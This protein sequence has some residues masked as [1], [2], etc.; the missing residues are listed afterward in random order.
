[1]KRLKKILVILLVINSIL[2]CQISFAL[3]NA[4]EK[5]TLRSAWHIDTNLKQTF[6]RMEI[7]N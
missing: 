1:M 4:L 5:S 7:G 2:I 3:D 6:R